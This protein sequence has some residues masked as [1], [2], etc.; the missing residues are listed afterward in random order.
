MKMLLKMVPRFLLAGILGTTLVA[1]G[2]T[3]VSRVD[4]DSAVDLTD[5]WN[6]T[7]SRQVSQQ[8][9]EDMVTF[10]WLDRW[11]QDHD[12]PPRVIIKTVRNKSHEHIPTDTF[13]NDLKRAMLRN[14]KVQFVSGGAARDEVREE[15][16]E[17]D[18]YASEDT[19]AE[20]GAESGA[21]FAL[22]GSI[23]SNVQ[24]AD[25]T[26]V[27]FYQVDL[28]LVDMTTTQEAWYGQ[29]KIKKV[30]EQGGLF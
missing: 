15:R 2:S 17:Q 10:P 27:T 3:T 18:L 19:R 14:G 16:K 22:S 5:E 23:N 28:T 29:K 21:D 30:A 24:Q 4:S 13:I 26:R 1:C 9:I 8:M 12:R 6:S 11:N 7:D 25:G 20:M